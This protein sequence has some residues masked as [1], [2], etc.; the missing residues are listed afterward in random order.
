MQGYNQMLQPADLWPVR[1]GFSAQQCYKSFT[2]NWNAFGADATVL[3]AVKDH[4]GKFLAALGLQFGYTCAQ[5]IITLNLL[6]L[7][8]M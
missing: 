5:F 1:E 4:R 8:G 3:K 7:I 2:E 6:W